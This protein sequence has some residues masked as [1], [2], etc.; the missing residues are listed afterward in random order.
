MY[1]ITSNPLP[2]LTIFSPQSSPLSST[3]SCLPNV[4]KTPHLSCSPTLYCSFTIKYLHIPPPICY[5]PLQKGVWVYPLTEIKNLSHW[6]KTWFTETA[7]SVTADSLFNSL[8]VFAACDWTDQPFL[9]AVTP[10]PFAVMLDGLWKAFCRE[11]EDSRFRPNYPTNYL[12][13]SPPLLLLR[14]H[15]WHPV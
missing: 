6:Q 10:F 5:S 14:S 3:T 7:C 2:L 8:N 13:I 15:C 4:G 12:C 9:A 1:R 11:S